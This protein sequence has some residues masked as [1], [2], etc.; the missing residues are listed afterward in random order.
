[1]ASPNVSGGPF[2]EKE[3]HEFLT[4]D[5]SRP[6]HYYEVELGPFGHHFDIDVDLDM[7]KSNTA[8]SSGGRIGATQDPARESATIE[9]EWQAPEIVRALVKGAVLPLALY[10]MEG[11]KPRLYLAWSPPRTPRP[12][13]HVPDAFGSLVLD[14]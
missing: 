1:M 14:P 13:F 7:K 10:R 9:V 8:W 5:P 6:R 2:G 12:N 4:P 11:Q 3:S